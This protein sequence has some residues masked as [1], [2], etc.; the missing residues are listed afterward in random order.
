MENLPDQNS[1]LTPLAPPIGQTPLVYNPKIPKDNG[2]KVTRFVL[3]V[4]FLLLVIAGIVLVY[5]FFKPQIDQQLLK[6]TIKKIEQKLTPIPTTDP[7]INWKTFTEKMGRFTF[8]YPTNFTLKENIGGDNNVYYATLKSNKEE[9][10]FSSGP[11]EKVG[12]YANFATGETQIINGITW[13][14]TMSEA[15]CDP[16]NCA[17]TAPGYYTVIKDFYVGVNQ[18]NKINDVSS[19]KSILATFTFA[20]AGTSKSPDQK[21]AAC[22]SN[23]DCPNGSTCMT[24]GPL[25]AGQPVKK[26]CTRPGTANPL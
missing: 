22:T 19:L 25:I 2:V 18:S 6:S 10:K 26:V 12:P 13:I 20:P 5:N 1:D 7:T 14:A 17:A 24:S 23:A 15:Y 8:K 21:Q 9:F 11:T 3:R 16:A 4:L